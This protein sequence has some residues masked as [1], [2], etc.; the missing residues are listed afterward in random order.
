MDEN[1]VASIVDDP[2]R[3][4]ITPWGDNNNSAVEEDKSKVPEVEQDE[5]FEDTDNSSEESEEQQTRMENN[6]QQ[7]QGT[8]TRQPNYQYSN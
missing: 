5:M 2:T 7:H 4:N 3:A 1:K 8:R 6:P